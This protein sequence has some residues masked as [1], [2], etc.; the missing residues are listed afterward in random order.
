MNLGLI[1]AQSRAG[2]IGRDGALPWRLPEDLAHFREVTSG[3]SVIMGRRTWES[4][5][6][7]FRPLPGR[8][9]LVIS[10]RPGYRAPGAEVAGSLPKAV[11]SA[12]AG[13]RSVWVI[14]GAQVYAEA[15]DLASVAAV[16]EVD[17]EV[18]DGDTFAPSLDGWTLT[19][20]GAWRTS[21]TGLR[22]R[23]LRYAR[24]GTS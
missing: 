13:D 12:T 6:A 15:Q 1:W 20:A 24:Q 17:V 16:T 4:L 5:P 7:R 9:N 2:V 19:S 23:F 8:R 3:H 10:R 14:G 11:R 21:T 18:P 22:Y